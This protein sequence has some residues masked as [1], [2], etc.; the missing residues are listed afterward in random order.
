ME[1]GGG[2]EDEGIRDLHVGDVQLAGVFWNVNM[3]NTLVPGKTMP[4]RLSD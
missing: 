2:P 4:S 1:V 3:N